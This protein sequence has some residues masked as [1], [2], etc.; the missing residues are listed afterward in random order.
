MV[1]ALAAML[2]TAIR[3]FGM[4]KSGMY[5]E[6]INY[7]TA[8][9][10]S[11]DFLE[12]VPPIISK[13][14]SQLINPLTLEVMYDPYKPREAQYEINHATYLIK[15]KTKA[16]VLEVLLIDI[17]HLTNGLIYILNK[18]IGDF[19]QNRGDLYNSVAHQLVMIR[20]YGLDLSKENP[21]FGKV[22]KG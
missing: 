17:V 22:K 13:S 14:R 20:S 15:P 4:D 11:T 10:D 18:I 7:L 6:V 1:N 16:E 5:N 21:T 2:N 9:R 12:F 3:D 8:S 19:Y